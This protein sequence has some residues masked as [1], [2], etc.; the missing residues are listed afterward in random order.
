MLDSIW[1]HQCPSSHTI[2]QTVILS[3]FF[4]PENFSLKLTHSYEA[5]CI[6][7][8]CCISTQE[9]FLDS[10]PHPQQL[11]WQSLMD[12]AG[13]FDNP[14][15]RNISSKATS[16]LS[17]RF[18]KGPLLILT[19]RLPASVHCLRWLL[20]HFYHVIAESLGQHIPLFHSIT[21]PLKAKA[22]FSKYFTQD[23]M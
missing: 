12:T 8:K 23:T 7:V 9:C 6:F 2:S 1:G 5:F 14:D 15:N 11:S 3:L 16:N 19:L 20:C 10:S 18:W 4:F 13:V 21:V 22:S 17:S